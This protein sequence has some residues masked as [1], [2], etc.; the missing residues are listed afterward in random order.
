MRE[1][2]NAASAF[3]CL[4][5]YKTGDLRWAFVVDPY[6]RVTQACSADTHV[7]ADSLSFGNP[8]PQLYK[9]RQFTIGEQYVPMI[10]DWQTVNTQDNDVHELF[11]YIGESMLTNA[12]V[13]EREDGQLYGYNCKV[14]KHGDR[15]NVEPN[16]RQMT[17]LHCNLKHAQKITFR[18]ETKKL[19]A[20]Y[21][22]WA[23]G[24]NE[25]TF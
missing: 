15:W 5:D 2:Y 23:F 25:Y 8:H 18:G 24:R 16:E 4:A 9:T 17:N 6:L 3:S 19:E 1:S 22:G 14:T 20:G 10:S 13:I 11:K 7:T 12:F 21:L